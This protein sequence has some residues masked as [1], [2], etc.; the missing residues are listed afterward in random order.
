MMQQNADAQRRKMRAG[1]IAITP[2]L[3]D[4]SSFDFT[5]LPRAIAVG[6]QAARARAEPLAAL[7]IDADD[8]E[9]YAAH[10]ASVRA[11]P[12]VP[13]FVRIDSDSDRYR[14]PLE[15]VFDSVVGR[16]IDDR[17]M[18]DRVSRLYGQG[19]LEALDYRLEPREPG[20]EEYGL[21]L[22]A[23]R[24]TWGPNYLRFGL[25]LQDDFEGNTSFNAAARMTLAEITT[26]GGEWVWD[27]QIGESPRIATE[28]YLPFG[29]RSRWFVAPRVD[30]GLRNVPLLE[31]GERVAEFRLRT[32]ELA[33]DVGREISNWGELRAG[34]RRTDG[35]SRVRLGDPALPE[36]RFDTREIFT[37]FRYDRLDSVDFPRRG[38]SF[39]LRWAAQREELGSDQTADL[40]S[41]DWLT[42]HSWGKHTAVFWTSGGTRLDSELGQIEAYF[43]LGG[44]LN[45]SGVDRG[46][47]SGPHFAIARGLYY[48]QIGRGGESILD[49]PVYAGVS[50][51]IGNV[52]QRRSDISFGSARKN[53]SVFLGLDTLIGPV[54]LGSG[55]DDDGE[56][57]FYLFLGR[58][59]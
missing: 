38:Q 19:N 22:S 11:P 25:N 42:A 34:I 23:R 55:F 24:N 16:P 59:F 1:D 56:S 18:A 54:Y 32:T 40:I 10:R 46:S 5:R 39:S 14:E 30:V 21:G 29:Y 8:Y 15:R 51:E 27:F 4:Y 45:L 2:T 31:N 26:P 20:S 37:Q 36:T 33:L 53:G 3:G 9:R 43:P 13:K 57:A 28:V 44:F 7:T 12:P 17:D 35:K 58:T 47:L 6:E 52:W 49:L 48:R 50:L 41:Y